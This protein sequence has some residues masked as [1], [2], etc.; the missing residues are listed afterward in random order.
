MTAA[1]RFDPSTVRLLT[2]DG[3]GGVVAHTASGA[4]VLQRNETAWTRFDESR[5]PT[6]NGTPLGQATVS[7]SLPRVAY[8]GS[9]R[10]ALWPGEVFRTADGGASWLPL[11][12]CD[13]Y[14]NASCVPVVD[15]HDPDTV[16]V[17]V[18]GVVITGEALIRISRDA[19]AT[20]IPAAVRAG[21]AFTVLPTTPTTLLL[22]VANDSPSGRYQLLESTDGGE[23]WTRTGRGLPA[24]IALTGIV[25][26]PRAPRRLFAGTQGR[27]VFRSDDGGATWAPAG[28]ITPAGR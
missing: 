15:P 5:L 26:D 6:A 11:G 20:W 1:E 4:F 9:R 2:P 3:S 25:A 13:S 28:P 14:V 18:G 27:G 21:Q 10:L 16:Y 24:N 12:P 8:A 19:G 7:P 17:Q 23:R 22:Q